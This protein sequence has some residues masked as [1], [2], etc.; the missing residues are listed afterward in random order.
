MIA[1][2]WIADQAALGA[3][4]PPLLVPVWIAAHRQIVEP[5]AGYVEFSPERK[6]REKSSLGLIVLLGVLTL[7][8]GIGAYFFVR[9]SPPE[10]DSLLPVVIPA[11]PAVLLAVGGILVGL[12]FGI[13][14]FLTY[15]VLL[16]IGGVVGALV[17]AEPGWHF[18]G[19]GV[20]ILVVGIVL[21]VSFLREN[22]LAEVEGLS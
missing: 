16:L 17:R 20:I 10:M 1:V 11:L 21:L 9:S 19:P 22:P 3:I 4:F 12:L 13:R 8:L 2:S 5:R 7:A 18:L 14:R 6:A 15:A